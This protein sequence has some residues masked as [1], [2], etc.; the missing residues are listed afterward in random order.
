MYSLSSDNCRCKSVTSISGHVFTAC[1]RN[2]QWRASIDR[3]WNPCSCGRRWHYNSSW[4]LGWRQASQ[5]Y[6]ASISPHMRSI[7]SSYLFHLQLPLLR[8]QQALIPPTGIF[9]IFVHQYL[10]IE[11]LPSILID[12]FV[13]SFWLMQAHFLEVPM[14]PF[15]ITID[16]MGQV[17]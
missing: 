5:C 13:C 6:L 4:L 8:S 3:S 1:P 17:V 2:I 12:S 10:C 14:F 7:Y 9:L 15:E 16:C 11:Q